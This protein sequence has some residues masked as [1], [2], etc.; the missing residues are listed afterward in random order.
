MAQ[1]LFA[2]SKIGTPDRAVDREVELESLLR[3]ALKKS[4][5]QA[6]VL[7]GNSQG[8]PIRTTADLPAS[9]RPPTIRGKHR[10]STKLRAIIEAELNSIGLG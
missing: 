5:C 4:R 10:R 3:D 9:P 1:L 2:D 7:A 8:S 6:E